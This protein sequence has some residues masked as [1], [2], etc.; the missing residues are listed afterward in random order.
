MK[1]D[2]FI[3]KKE[4]RTKE[5]QNN[6]ERFVCCVCLFLFCYFDIWGVVGWGGGRVGIGLVGGVD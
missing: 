4:R 2:F 5:K 3:K 1:V 6:R